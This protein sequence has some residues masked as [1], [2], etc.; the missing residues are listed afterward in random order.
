MLGHISKVTICSI[1]IFQQQHLVGVFITTAGFNV[2]LNLDPADECVIPFLT[3]S[4]R[5]RHAEQ[6]SPAAAQGPEGPKAGQ[7]REGKGA[8]G[9]HWPQG[10]DSQRSGTA[11]SRE[12]TWECIWHLRVDNR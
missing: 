6:S 9:A 2:S 5:G 8:T 11:P 1:K 12:E 4:N 3:A 7:W 10:I